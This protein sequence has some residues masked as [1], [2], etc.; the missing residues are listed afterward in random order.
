MQINDIN[1][2]SPDDVINLLESIY[3]TLSFCYMLDQ[4]DGIDNL[5]DGGTGDRS[6]YILLNDVDLV[7][8]EQ[9]LEV[10]ASALLCSVFT[11]S[12]VINALKSSKDKINLMHS[13]C[14]CFYKDNDFGKPK[15]TKGR[16]K[17]WI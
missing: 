7:R 13:N 10:L 2:D 15:N 3:K 4:D 5:V 17:T 16:K 14:I 8:M 6:G 11:A 9:D 12:G 1:L